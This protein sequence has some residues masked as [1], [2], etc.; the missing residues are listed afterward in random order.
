MNFNSLI[1]AMEYW[2]KLVHQFIDKYD[3][4]KNEKEFWEVD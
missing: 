1:E 2:I 4:K 3:V